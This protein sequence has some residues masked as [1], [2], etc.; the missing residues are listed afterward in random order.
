MYTVA[1]G[2]TVIVQKTRRGLNK[3][4]ENLD[5]PRVPERESVAST[6]ELPLEDGDSPKIV[7]KPVKMRNNRRN[8]QQEKCSPEHKEIVTFVTD[9]WVR[10]KH[11]MDK[12]PGKV[13]YYQENTNPRL[14]GFEPFDLD[15]WWGKKL[16]HN[17]TNGV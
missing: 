9:G 3:N 11:E 15:A 5:A 2:P 16:Y 14:S 10:V 17:L 6:P 1:K 7:F 13:R 12:D 4:L 8:L